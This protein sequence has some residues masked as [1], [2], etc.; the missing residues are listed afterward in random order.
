[1]NNNDI[2]RRIRYTFDFSDSKMI[3]LFGLAGREVTRAQVSDWL[4]KD[5]DPEVKELD[6]EHLAV[7]L[8]GLIN[9][10][11]GK[12]EGPQPEPE[13]RLNNNI[14]FRKLKIALDLKDEDIL[15]ILELAN[16]RLGRHELSAFF[17]NPSQ[18]Q[19]R[20]CKDQVLRNFLHG[21]QIKYHDGTN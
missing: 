2:L 4:K 10:R 21:M 15:H 9:D 11:R 16:F 14:I 17:R 20:D 7:F 18:S 5:E 12:K 6:D 13:K 1:M 8:N 3:E 19:Y